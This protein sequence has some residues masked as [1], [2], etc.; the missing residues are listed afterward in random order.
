MVLVQSPEK[1][2]TRV[3][4]VTCRRATFLS[5]ISR[6]CMRSGFAVRDRS[7]RQNQEN[8]EV[9]RFGRMSYIDMQVQLRAFV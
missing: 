9:P 7:E 3:V 1:G 4:W 5:P 6:N 2:I 8:L